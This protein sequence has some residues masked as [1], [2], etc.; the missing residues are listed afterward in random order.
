MAEEMS[1][2]LATLQLSAG[3][4]LP[5]GGGGGGGRDGG[6][7]TP[8]GAGRHLITFADHFRRHHA[9]LCVMRVPPAGGSSATSR[10][11]VVAGSLALAY[12]SLASLIGAS[13]VPP[14]SVPCKLP[15]A[16]AASLTQPRRQPTTA[17]C[18]SRRDVQAS[19]WA[20]SCTLLHRVCVDQGAKQQLQ[21]VQGPAPARHGPPRHRR[22]ARPHTVPPPPPVSPLAAGTI[23]LYEEQYQPDDDN[24]TPNK[25]A[26]QFSAEG[27]YAKAVFEYRGGGRDAIVP[28]PPIPSRPAGSREPAAYLQ[29]PEFSSCTVP[30]VF[31]PFWVRSRS[32]RRSCGEHS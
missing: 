11:L 10:L 6:G 4:Y 30:I 32:W 16:A 26:P 25:P 7:A 21:R 17:A 8:L 1:S 23:V 24:G 22:I 15:A 28:L 3:R 20:E 29:D 13:V 18:P 2:G 27:G 14:G 5:R 31:Y 19:A 12:Y 9:F